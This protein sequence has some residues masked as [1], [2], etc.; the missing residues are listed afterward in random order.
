MPG[1]RRG[2]EGAT[3]AASGWNPAMSDLPARATPM[4]LPAA[5][6]AASLSAATRRAYRADW[7]DFSAWCRPSAPTAFSNIRRRIMSSTYD[8]QHRT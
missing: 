4:A 5:D 2:E 3:I 6:A 1:Y 7:A 8:P